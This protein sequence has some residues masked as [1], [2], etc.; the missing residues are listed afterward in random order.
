M[1][2]MFI[3]NHESDS[4]HI[5]MPDIY[6]VVVHFKKALKIRDK[7]YLVHPKSVFGL[8]WLQWTG[9][10]SKDYAKT[11]ENEWNALQKYA[12]PSPIVT[13]NA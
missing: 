11:W 2:K 13:G 6:V 9:T 10:I 4:A 12:S 5:R 7:H 8:L 1:V 3:D